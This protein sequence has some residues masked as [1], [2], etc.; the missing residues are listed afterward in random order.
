[1]KFVIVF[2][3]KSKQHNKQGL[4]K[5]Y[6]GTKLPWI[7][8]K[9]EKIIEIHQF[10]PKMIRISEKYLEKYAS[11]CRPWAP[12]KLSLNGGISVSGMSFEPRLSSFVS[13]FASESDILPVFY[14][15]IW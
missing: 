2:D 7:L 1:M 10:G 5:D 9:S 4:E 12:M 15:I 13:T 14:P 11:G 3:K 8:L 6:S